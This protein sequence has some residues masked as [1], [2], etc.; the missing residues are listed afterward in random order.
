VTRP[1]VVL[2]GAPGAGKTTVGR[3]LA[4]RL[5]I[6]FLDTDQLIEAQ[7]GKPVAEI[8]FDDGEEHF[9]ELETAAVTEALETH[10]GVLALGG[11]AV[12]SERT[13]TALRAHR[14]VHLRVGVSDAATRVGF[15]ANRPVLA[16][17]PRATLKFLLEERAPLYAEVATDVVDTDGRTP[18]AVADEIASMLT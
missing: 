8:F 13:R 16:L 18:D 11:G 6:A 3:R 4:H 1:A 5:D 17:N 15:G 9:R 7:V 12:L 14:V 10:E 2:V